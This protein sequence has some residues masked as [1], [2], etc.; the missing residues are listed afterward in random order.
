MNNRIAVIGGGPAGMMA[1][2]TAAVAGAHVVLFERNDKLGKKLY[3]TGKGRCNFTNN[4]D[5]ESFFEALPRNGKFMRGAYSRF[6]NSD[7]VALMEARGVPTKVERGGRVFPASDKS[8]DII[9]ALAGFVRDS[10]AVVELG[11]RVTAV[12]KDSTDFTVEHN[13][14]S[15]RFA[16]VILACG[17]LS[18]PSTGSDGDG[19]AFA[20]AFGH[21]IITARPSLIPIVT[22]ETWPAALSGLSLKNVALNAAVNSKKVFSE[23]GEMLF[24]HF[25]VSGPLVLKCS[26]LLPE[27]M[28]GVVL[29]IDMKPGLSREQLEARIQRDLDKSA[30]KQLQ[31]AFGDLLPRS[32]IPIVIELSGVDPQKNVDNISRIE[33]RALCDILKC[34]PLTPLCT[35]PIDE[36]IV[37]RG[38]VAVGGVKSSSMESRIAG[39]LYFAGEMIDVDGFT[40]GYNIQIAMSTGYLAGL[41]AAERMSKECD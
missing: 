24:T 29:S 2:A 15:D 3:L 7:S 6:D 35:R 41:S 40:G 8:S 23:V 36:A 37:T 13:G 12:K 5:N 1:A 21:E 28:S 22:K 17:G 39:G 9:R 16:A 18:Y 10:G 30:R 31:N 11:C 27:D 19:Y 33:R 14:I 4:C 20:S 32:M 34:I 25:G 26:A 38:G